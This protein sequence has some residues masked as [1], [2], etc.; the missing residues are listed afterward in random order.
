MTP[1]HSRRRESAPMPVR[2]LIGAIVALLVALPASAAAQLPSG[3]TP[4]NGSAFQ[5][6]DGNQD[7]EGAFVDWQ[8]LAARVVHKS[9]PNANDDE[10]KGGKQVLEPEDWAFTTANAGVEPAKNNI[11]DAWSAVDQ[12]A[13]DTFLYLAFAREDGTG[14]AALTFELN[15]RGGLWNNGHAD[16][17]CRTD[18]DILIV[19]KP[20]GNASEVAIVLYEWETRTYDARTGCARTGRLDEVTRIPAGTAQ[21]RANPAPITSRL[22]GFFAPGSQIP[23]RDFSEVALNLSDLMQDAFHDR[24]FA[25]T[26]MW[27]HSRSSDSE[28]SNMSDYVA[29]EPVNVRTCSASGTKF[30]D[31]NANGVR[32]S[33]EPGLPRFLI[34]ADYD[35]DGRRDANEPF[36]VTDDDGDYVI[37]DIR[38]PSGSYR[39]RETLARSG[40]PPRRTAWRCSYPNAGTSGGFGNGRGGLF[41]CGWGPTSVGSTPNAQ[42]RDFGNWL[43]AVLTVEKQ[44]WPANDPGRFDLIVN[45]VTVKAAAGD[46]DRVTLLVAPGTYNISESAAAGTD[47]SL[48]TSS[49]RCR[50]VTRRRSVLRSGTAWSGLALQAAS[51]GFCRF[52]NV[53]AGAPAIDIEKT[54]PAF[55][56][57]GDTLRYSLY[58]TN[59][60]DL[61][62]PGDSVEVTDKGCDDPPKLTTR[63]GDTSPDTLDPGDTWTYACSRTT[64]A[65]GDDCEVVAFTNVADVT[66]SV[67]GITVSDNGSVTT[68]IACPDKPPDPPIPPTPEPGPEPPVVPP[69][70]SP[71]PSPPVVPPGPQPPTA[72]AAGVA[73]ISTSNVRC[74][75]RASQIHLTGER[76]HVLSVSVDGRPLRTRVVRLLARRVIPLTRVIAPGR[77]VL[78]IRVSFERGSATAPVTL[79]RAITVCGRAAAAPRVTG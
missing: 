68:T 6:G 2:G 76:M 57:A 77:Y 71:S 31:L 35:N 26:S 17:P 73:G 72:G 14:T 23:A 28:N 18:G 38:P 64:A 41:R 47:P 37:D 33:G 53:R 5:G 60:G 30:F 34:W 1:R 67:G 48:Y 62:I 12:P 4:L 7:D 3:S 42:G 9:D 32:D 21:G 40:G 27:M 44:L 11:L 56:Q 50:A 78:S 75:S 69:L 61:A 45:G 70:P 20:H 25:F 66:G 13:A 36:S 74:I 24:C 16:I 8:G 63:N 49:V 58:V 22:G 52:V 15:R 19:T 55:A 59:P 54:G 46:G 43:P 79:T 39:L 51:L 29:P 10:F 65:A